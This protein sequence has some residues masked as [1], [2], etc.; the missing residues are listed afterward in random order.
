MANITRPD[1][2]RE[3][4]RFDPFG[5]DFPGFTRGLRRMFQEMPAEPAIRLEVAEDDKAYKVKAD[6]PGVKKEDIEVEIEGDA[7]VISAEVRRE[8]DE[9][10]DGT[11]VH[12]ERYYGRQSRRFSL[13]RGIDRDKAEA[14][15]DNGVLELTLPKNGKASP[16][17]IAIR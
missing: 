17:R 7:V 10:K 2:F 1:P 11:V 8:K 5:E 14:R 3:L 15:Y 6:L 12:S 4:S 16:N 13:P 9:K